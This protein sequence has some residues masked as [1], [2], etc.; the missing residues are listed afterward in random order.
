MLIELAVVL[1]ASQLPCVP[2]AE[3]KEPPTIIVQV[4][5]PVWLPVPGAQI[6]VKQ[7]AR[8]E[9]VQKAR[10]DTEGRARFW[11]EGDAE[12][13]I[14][15]FYPGFRKARVHAVRLTRAPATSPFPTAY[16]QIRLKLARTAVT[17]Y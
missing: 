3:P 9:I 5:D 6:E 4:V 8:R 1:V 17:V 2:A 14:E 15:A 11:L 7:R 13:D 12:Y 10:S 16:V